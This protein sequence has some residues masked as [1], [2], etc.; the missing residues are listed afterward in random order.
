ME[1][2]QIASYG[3]TRILIGPS[4]IVKFAA[5]PFAYMQSL[6]LISAAATLEI[7]Q[8]PPALVGTSAVGWGLGY[9]VG[10]AE[11]FN[12]VGPA[13][14]YLAS[15]GFAGATVIASIAYGY[16]NGATTI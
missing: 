2:S 16:T 11:I 7:V 3:A 14:F 9:P 10:A 6:K 1:Q 8:C 4:A 5:P 12:S 13:T 15:S